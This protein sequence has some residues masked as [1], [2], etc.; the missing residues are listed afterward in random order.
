MS[1]TPRPVDVRDTAGPP[2]LNSGQKLMVFVLSMTLFGL[3]N[4]LTEVLP[5]VRIGPVEISVSYLAF[6]PVVMASLFHPLYAALGAPLG[7]IVFVDLLMGDFSGLG[8]LEGY[9]QMFLAVYIGGCLVRDPRRRGQLFLAAVTVVV[10]DKMLSAIVDIGKVM[11][12]V[13]DAEYVPGLPESIL[14]LEGVGFTTDV[15]ISGVLF[16]A[17]PAM[18]LAPRLY[19]KIEPLLG[20][21]PRDPARPH[22]LTERGTGAFLLL[23]LVLAF[24]SMIAAFTSEIF[25][26]FGVWEPDFVD[27][28]GQR[29]LWIGVSAAVIV[30]AA[31]VVAI[32]FVVHSRRERAAQED[33]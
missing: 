15:I 24:V 2:A 1:A 17:L 22:P 12:G 23:A 14:L 31:L 32:R 27:Q 16:G 20:L 28:Y 6:V 3:A 26:N 18:I 9:L 19:G 4:I 8:E 10:V 7:E 30:L 29:F 25:D 33:R 5:E 21:A 13:E 11:V